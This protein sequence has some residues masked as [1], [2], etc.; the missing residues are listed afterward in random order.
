MGRGIDTGLASI[1]KARDFQECP[2]ATP[3]LNGADRP[4]ATTSVSGPV[5]APRP[6][7]S[8][9]RKG[10]YTPQERRVSLTPRL[11]RDSREQLPY[12]YYRACCQ[13]SSCRHHG[14]QGDCPPCRGLTFRP[15]SRSFPPEQQQCPRS[16]HL[17]CPRRHLPFHIR[18]EL[19]TPDPPRGRL[20]TAQACLCSPPPHTSNNLPGSGSSQ[21]RSALRHTTQLNGFALIVSFRAGDAA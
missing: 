13:R 7:L 8:L 14:P 16:S 18:V 19:P 17:V 21:T 4:I 1:L 12:F 20:L 5:L 10:K 6:F 11:P 15:S 3:V 9:Q 2:I